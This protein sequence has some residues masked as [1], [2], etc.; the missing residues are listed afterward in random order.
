[1]PQ[2]PREQ[3]GQLLGQTVSVVP[4]SPLEGPG[5]PFL[6]QKQMRAGKGLCSPAPN[7]GAPAW[8]WKG[9]RGTVRVSVVDYTGH[10][11]PIGPPQQTLKG[12]EDP[13]FLGPCPLPTWPAWP[14]P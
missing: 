3:N 2:G 5:F 11:A 10:P 6:V 8:P 7:Y 1:M 4:R 14:R 12:W 9:A 13:A